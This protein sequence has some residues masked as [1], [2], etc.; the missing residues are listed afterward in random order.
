MIHGAIKRAFAWCHSEDTVMVLHTC[1]MD[2]DS[3]FRPT[4]AF[5]GIPKPPSVVE[6]L[7][8]D[9]GRGR[10]RPRFMPLFQSSFLYARH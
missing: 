1:E 3:R 2:N 7:E 8:Q 5:G 6:A 9:W 4:A 10:T